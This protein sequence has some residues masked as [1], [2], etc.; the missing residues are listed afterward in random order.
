MS[1]PGGLGPGSSDFSFYT[2]G[3]QPSPSPNMAPGVGNPGLKLSQIQA[4]GQLSSH[5]P[6]ENGHSVRC[7][8]INVIVRE[9]NSVSMIHVLSGKVVPFLFYAGAL[10][11]D[12]KFISWSDVPWCCIW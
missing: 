8:I 12:P 11:E 2:N 7:V 1:T 4:E 5:A 9:Y 10:Q 6:F 3:N